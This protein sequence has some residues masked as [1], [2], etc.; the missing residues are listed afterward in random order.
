MNWESKPFRDL[1]RERF[2]YLMIDGICNPQLAETVVPCHSNLQRHGHGASIR[3]HDIFT[4]PGC[5]ACHTWLDHGPAAR[6]DKEAAFMRAWERWM[7]YLVASG[8]LALSAAHT[9]EHPEPK[10]PRASRSK[11]K[12]DLRTRR[13]VPRTSK[14]TAGSKTVPRR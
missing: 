11:T 1:C 5:L 13:K 10:L 8:E 6:A 12:I 7:L 4:V 3:S 14:T 2:C 9:A